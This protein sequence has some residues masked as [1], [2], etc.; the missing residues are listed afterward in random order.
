MDNVLVVVGGIIPPH[1]AEAL[2]AQ[3]V[4]AVYGPGTRI[5]AAAA[6]ILEELH[7]RIEGYANPQAA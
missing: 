7:K 2:I 6:G 3:G 5:P 1:D 4:H